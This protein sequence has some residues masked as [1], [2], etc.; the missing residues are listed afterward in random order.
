MYYNVIEIKINEM[1]QS[2]LVEWSWNQWL[3]LRKSFWTRR[4]RKKMFLPSFLSFWRK[5]KNL[6][7]VCI[8]RRPLIENPYTYSSKV[9]GCL[10]YV[11]SFTYLFQIMEDVSCLCI[12]AV[13][14]LLVG[15]SVN[16]IFIFMITLISCFIHNNAWIVY[17]MEG[18]QLYGKKLPQSFGS[19]L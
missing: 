1:I 17:N 6:L 15:S 3:L 11:T 14:V 5:F 7:K 2:F 19:M 12:V 18:Q 8:F 4:S 10:L 16:D 13:S 9:A